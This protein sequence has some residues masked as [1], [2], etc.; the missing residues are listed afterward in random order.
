MSGF[1]GKNGMFPFGISIDYDD[2][3]SVCPETWTKVVH[4]L[5]SAGANVFCV[6]ARRP[7]MAI[8]DF[9]GEVYYTSGEPKAQYMREQYVDVNI[10]VDDWPELIGTTRD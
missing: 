7:D 1:E 9:P 2:T 6:T 4:L 10:W 5:R 8:T 3:F